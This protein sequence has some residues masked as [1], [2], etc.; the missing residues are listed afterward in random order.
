M[1]KVYREIVTKNI[2]KTQKDIRYMVAYALY[3]QHKKEFIEDYEEKNGESPGAEKLNEFQDSSLTQ[4]SIENLYA[5]TDKILTTYG[6]TVFKNK[7][8]QFNK[9]HVEIN[10]KKHFW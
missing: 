10:R 5:K 9:I 3:K 8:A 6:N 1:S 2:K 4:T 7:I